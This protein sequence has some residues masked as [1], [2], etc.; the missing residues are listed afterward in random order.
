MLVDR[1][2]P[3]E[4]DSAFIELRG[5]SS[6]N[7]F[8]RIEVLAKAQLKFIADTTKVTDELKE[9]SKDL[10]SA[11]LNEMSTDNQKKD[12]PKHVQQQR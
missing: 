6:K 4:D 3:E 12:E 9:L 5:T 7:F 11:S 8:A 2:Y 1:L 10:N